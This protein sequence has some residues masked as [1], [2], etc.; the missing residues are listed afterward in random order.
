MLSGN[1]LFNVLGLKAIGHIGMDLHG[2]WRGLLSVLWA[3]V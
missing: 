1:L 3:D 2:M